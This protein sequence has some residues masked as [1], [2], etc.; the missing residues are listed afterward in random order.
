MEICTQ[1]YLSLGFLLFALALVLPLSFVL[2]IGSC[3]AT[4]AV[5]ELGVILLPLSPE[6]WDYTD[7]MFAVSLS[8]EG[9]ETSHTG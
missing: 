9:C 5:L 7:A 3:C 2:E 6:S 8:P 1:V 4:P